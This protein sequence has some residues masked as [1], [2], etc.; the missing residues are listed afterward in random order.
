[1]LKTMP[2]DSAILHYPSKTLRPRRRTCYSS[3]AGQVG[4]PVL[5]LASRRSYPMSRSG[6]LSDGGRPSLSPLASRLGPNLWGC[7]GFDPWFACAAAL[8]GW[9]SLL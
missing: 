9:T 7:S 4:R 2:Q 1:M 3:E 8:G 6:S 5:W